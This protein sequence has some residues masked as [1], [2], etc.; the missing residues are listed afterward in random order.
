MAITRIEQVRVGGAQPGPRVSSELV[1][2]PPGV[3]LGSLLTAPLA[4]SAALP[5]PLRPAAAGGAE[6]PQRR[7]GLVPGGAQEPGLLRLRE[8]QA[9]DHHQPCQA[10]VVRGDPESRGG[11]AVR[12]LA[13]TPAVTPSGMPAGTPPPLQPPATRRPTSRSCS[14]SWTRPS[15]WT[16]SRTSR[17][18]RLGHCPPQPR[19]PLASQL[20]NGASAHTSAH[21]LHRTPLARVPVRLLSPVCLA[22]PPRPEAPRRCD[23]RPAEHPSWRPRGAG[24]EGAPAGVLGGSPVPQPSRCP[25]RTSLVWPPRY[26]PSWVAQHGGCC[27]WTRWPPLPS[28][29]PRPLG[30]SRRCPDFAGWA[31]LWWGSPCARN[32]GTAWGGWQEGACARPGTERAGPLSAVST[33]TP[34][35]GPGPR[36]GAVRL[37]PPGAQG[38]GQAAARPPAQPAH[39]DTVEAEGFFSVPPRQSR[40][41]GER[42]ARADGQLEESGRFPHPSQGQI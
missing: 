9:A 19:Q 39:S 35:E 17:R 1:E 36:V 27:A 21:P 26:R 6:V 11:W 8:A 31:G 13:L 23:F 32:R 12:G 5:V 10:R 24:G 2:H 29:S 15:T 38:S 40:S 20:K 37:H 4:L 28:P 3:A 16:P 25:R 33:P 22:A 42:S 14:A 30:G 34:R 7:A 18:R 41:G